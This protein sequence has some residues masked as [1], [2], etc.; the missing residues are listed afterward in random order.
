MNCK[1]CGAKVGEVHYSGCYLLSI[2]HVHRGLMDV[3]LLYPPISFVSGPPAVDNGEATRHNSGKPPLDLVMECQEALS[4][5]AMAM[6]SGASNYGRGDWKNGQPISNYLASAGRH[7]TK[8]ASGENTCPS[9]GHTHL[10]AAMA[11]IAMAIETLK[12]MPAMDNRTRFKSQDP[13]E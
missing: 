7:L 8:F 11:N 1:I 5:M 9:D 2:E 4:Q 10:G 3:S 6:E 13:G 12:H